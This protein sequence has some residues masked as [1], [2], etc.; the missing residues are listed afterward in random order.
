MLPPLAFRIENFAFFIKVLI[1]KLMLYLGT[2]LI[3]LHSAYSGLCFDQYMPLQNRPFSSIECTK[4]ILINVKN[5][6]GNMRKVYFLFIMYI[7]T[8][9]LSKV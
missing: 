9:Y 7:N 2:P 1:L 3:I 4:V 5:I 6:I 8:K